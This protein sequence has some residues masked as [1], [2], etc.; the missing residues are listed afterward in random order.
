[1][2]ISCWRLQS[3]Q[4]KE[5]HFCIKESIFRLFPSCYCSAQYL[6][7]IFWLYFSVIRF[8]WFTK[9]KIDCFSEYEGE[10]WLRKVI[11]SSFTPI[12]THEHTQTHSYMLMSIHKHTLIYKFTQMLM[13]MH[14]HTELQIHMLIYT[15]AHAH[16]YITTH[17]RI[18]TCA[19]RY[20][21]TQYAHMLVCTH[22]WK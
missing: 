21:Y 18:Y 9:K 6:D 2:I 10:I 4:N 1:M 8:T 16:L 12:L 19:H 13:R 22:I 15:H 14:T 5:L 3:L 20:S 17:K 7:V 11:T